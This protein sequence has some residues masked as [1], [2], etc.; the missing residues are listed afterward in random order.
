MADQH[1]SDLIR[2]L[3]NVPNIVGGLGLSIA[4]AQKAFDMEYLDAIERIVAMVKSILGNG[5]VGPDGKPFPE[6]LAFLQDMLVKLAPARYQYT[7]TT[8]SVRMDLAQSLQ[9]S[10]SVGLGFGIGAIS[11]NAAFTLGYSYDYRAAAQCQTVIHAVAPDA[12]VFNALLGRAATINDKSLELPPRAQVDQAIMDKQSTILQGLTG[13]TA[14]HIKTKPSIT[15]LGPATGQH[16]NAV[17]VTITGSGFLTNATVHV[18]DSHGNDAIPA[19]TPIQ[20][21]DTS[22]QA[23]IPATTPAGSYQLQ[24]ANPDPDNTKSDPT[25][26][27]NLV[28]T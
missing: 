14:Q 18:L 12:T 20:A 6:A 28:I 16:G 17:T 9:F 19:L 21:G 15:K 13:Q 3:S 11:V 22:L 8:L 10:G 1:A 5:I 2:D 7:E 23:T 26:A 25:A 24:I 27:A 4:S